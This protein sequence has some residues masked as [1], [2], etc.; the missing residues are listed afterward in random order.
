MVWN[1]VLH[2]TLHSK[3]KLFK[4]NY[5]YHKV[6]NTDVYAYEEKYADFCEGKLTELSTL[7]IV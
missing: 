4:V 5:Y 7:V 6:I 3:I 1:F 2:T